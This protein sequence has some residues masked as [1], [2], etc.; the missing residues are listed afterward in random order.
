MF[1]SKFTRYPLL[2]P[3][4]DY[5][6]FDGDDILYLPQNR[7]IQLNENIAADTTESLAAPS[8]VVERETRSEPVDNM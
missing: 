4:V 3:T 7:V 6:L 1:L 8:K 2:G 5:L